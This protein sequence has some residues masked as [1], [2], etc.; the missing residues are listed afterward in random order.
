MLV[1]PTGAEPVTGMR[2][3]SKIP[4][5]VSRPITPVLNSVNHMLPSGPAVIPVTPL[6]GVGSANSVNAPPGAMRP[7]LFALDSTNHRFRS[8]AEMIWVQIPFL[9]HSG[10]LL[11][12]S[13]MSLGGD[14][15]RAQRDR[16]AGGEV[17]RK[18]V[19]Q[20]IEQNAA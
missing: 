14:G 20:S 3:S 1:G 2:N 16:I 11:A 8:G 5:G 18:G 19:P 15:R 17:I 7:I 4:S 9:Q 13:C 10:S 12:F 6:S